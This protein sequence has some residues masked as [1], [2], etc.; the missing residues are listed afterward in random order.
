MKTFRTVF[1]AL[2]FVIA[3]YYGAKFTFLG[4]NYAG[5]YAFIGGLFG[6][7]VLLVVDIL[8]IRSVIK[9]LAAKAEATWQEGQSATEA[10]QA[11]Q[12]AASQATSPQIPQPPK[13]S[14]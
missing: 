7:A 14:N 9:S 5:D 1:L 8:I 3:N 12:Q 10:P 6:G 2:L 11:A 4:L 13:G